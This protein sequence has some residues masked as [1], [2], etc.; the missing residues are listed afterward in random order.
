MGGP[1]TAIATRLFP[2]PADVSA[3][4][5]TTAH[6]TVTAELAD[7]YGRTVSLQR[8]NTAGT[9]VIDTRAIPSGVYILLLHHSNGTERHKLIIQH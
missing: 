2:N 3:T 7:I 6:G 4:I 5:A 8:H 1:T 9:I